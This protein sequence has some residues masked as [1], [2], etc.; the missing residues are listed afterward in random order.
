VA[1]AIVFCGLRLFQTNAALSAI[2][3]AEEQ[4]QSSNV[5]PAVLPAGGF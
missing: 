4:Y 5:A 1:Q 2:L 3:T